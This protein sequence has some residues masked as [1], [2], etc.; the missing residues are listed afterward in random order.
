M[1]QHLAKA[2]GKCTEEEYRDLWKAIFSLPQ[3]DELEV[4]LN[5]TAMGVLFK[6]LN[7]VFAVWVDTA[8]GT[9]LKAID[10]QSLANATED[11]IKLVSH[12]TQI[13]PFISHIQ[14]SI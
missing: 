3:L 11:E 1:K 12:F 14:G 8:S 2:P 9:K 13:N 7:T 10:F 6:Y 5:A 4:V